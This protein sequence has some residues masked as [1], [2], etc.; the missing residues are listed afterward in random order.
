MNNYVF[1]NKLDHLAL[2]YIF[3]FLKKKNLKVY[4][5][6]KS[7]ILR[8]FNSL[9]LFQ[10]IQFVN[11]YPDLCE[12]I[13][14]RKT[15]LYLTNEEVLK[16]AQK[17]A[18]PIIKKN[19]LVNLFENV[20]SKKF[21]IIIEHKIALDI[22][23][24]IVFKNYIKLNN[25]QDR[26]FLFI[27][28]SDLSYTLKKFLLL[29]EKKITYKVLPSLNNLIII[30]TIFTV[31]RILKFFLFSKK[32]KRNLNNKKKL[33]IHY[34]RNFDN[35]FND[36]EWIDKSNIEKKN[37]IYYFYGKKTH[38]TNKIIH[39]IIKRGF[40][41][42]II[43]HYS[44][45]SKYQTTYPR[46]KFGYFMKSMGRI[47]YLFFFHKVIKVSRWEL[48]N[49]HSFYF[50]FILFRSFLEEE[51]IK[52][53]KD[54][55]EFDPDIVSLAAKSLNVIKIGIQWSDFVYP[56]VKFRQSQDF[57][58][59]W[60]DNVSKVFK[61]Y[62][63]N[64][65]THFISVG[66]V[67]MN[68]ENEKHVNKIDFK[69][70][71]Q[72]VVSV[73]DR[74][75]GLISNI[76]IN[77]HIEF[78][79]KIIKFAIKHSNVKLLVKPKG[80]I[81]EKILNY[82]NVTKNLNY[83]RKEKRIEILDHPTKVYRP[84]FE[85]SFSISLGHNTAG[86]ISGLLNNVSFFWDP[87]KLSNIDFNFPYEKG[88]FLNSKNVFLSLDELLK[89]IIDIDNNKNTYDYYLFNNDIIKEKN[90]YDDR[91]AYERIGKEIR[92]LYDSYN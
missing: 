72:L 77:H 43:D 86:I 87:S 12:E 19:I 62:Y 32:N 88:L 16:I 23:N 5:I 69:D 71:K 26:S 54:D 75:S 55:S 46:I 22:Y 20:S 59:T 70:K 14:E 50:K 30:R 9:F 51:N 1:V 17:I 39:D 44:N 8:K 63:L 57:Y 13:K 89:H 82:K 81:N 6:E 67:Y 52:I 28:L 90:S 80:E 42:R 91:K 45:R 35:I 15:N 36:M 34:N 78:Y 84:I 68:K 25:I 74:S 48:I 31:F 27:Q 24:L 38:A 11:F 79:D 37:I 83:L 4:Y 40:D 65:T 33:A 41:Y 60:S 56:F 29:K 64:N 66:C 10:K 18:E 58:F 73:F 53:I 76:G 92:N 47:I 3:F 61:D 21:Q 7:V 85:S 49:W 2:L